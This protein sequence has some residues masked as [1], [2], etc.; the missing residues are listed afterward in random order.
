MLFARKW[1]ELEINMYAKYTRLR[2]ISSFLSNVD[3]RLKTKKRHERK[4]LGREGR[5][6]ERVM[7]LGNVD[8]S[9]L[10]TCMKMS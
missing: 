5:R 1:M 2:Q 4:Y 10:Y 8:Q 9:T 3:C 7:T 6:D